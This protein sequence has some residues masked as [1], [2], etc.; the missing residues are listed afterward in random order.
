MILKASSFE[1]AFFICII[2]KVK[3]KSS[4][5]YYTRILKSKK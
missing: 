3:L 1:G 2:L 4:V 5:P